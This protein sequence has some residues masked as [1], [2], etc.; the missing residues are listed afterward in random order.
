MAE[1][2]VLDVRTPD[3]WEHWL[4]CNHDAAQE[5]WLR[6]LNKNAPSARPG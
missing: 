1:P 3:Q 6:L 4:E 5:V 2:V